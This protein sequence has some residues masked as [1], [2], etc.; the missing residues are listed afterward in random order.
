MPRS[1][2]S[3]GKYKADQAKISRE[4][5]AEGRDIGDVPK[6][7]NVRRK[8]KCSLSFR[9]FCDTYLPER[10]PLSWSGDHLKAIAKL[11]TAVLE[12]G[13]FAFA[14]PRG[15]GKTT[16][17]ESAALWA[18]LY[19]HRSFVVLIGSTEAAAEEMLESIKIELETNDEL[20]A[21]FPEVCFPIRAL[22]GISNRCKGQTI[23]GERT[24]IEWTQKDIV[25]PTVQKSKASGAVL[26]VAGITGRI[27]GMK[28]S[29]SDGRIIRPDFVIPDDPQTDDSAVSVTQNDYREK[30][31]AGAVL[32]L[33][34]PK[35][36]ISAVMPCTVI[37]P[38]DMADR[39]LNR[40]IHPE[41]NG[42]R[43]KMVYAFPTDTEKWERYAE[44]RKDGMRAGDAGK[45]ATEFYAENREAMDAGS[46]VAWPD[47]FNA[48][49]LSAIQNAMNMQ[50][51]NPR[52]F[53]AEAQNEPL[54]I[55]SGPSTE[56]TS[57]QIL[58]KLN[59]MPRG[60]IPRECTRLT[61]FIDVGQQVLI[62][63][64][65]A[66]DERFGGAAVDYGCF[67]VQNRDY[68]DTSDPRPSLSDTFPGCSS[69]AL[70]YQGLAHLVPWLLSR[71]W[72]QDQTGQP[73][74]IN[75]L[76]VD[77]GWQAETVFKYVRES[78]LQ[79]LVNGSKGHAIKAR[80]KP[81]HEWPV[82]E[83]TRPIFH[84]R[85]YPPERGK[86]R[87]VLFDANGWKSFF[88]DRLRVPKGT[89]GGFNLF[90]SEAETK[91]GLHRALIE[92]LTSERE[93]TVKDET[94]GR[95]KTEWQQIPHRPNHLWDCFVGCCVAAAVD[96]LQWSPDATPT[97]KRV[98]PK[99]DFEAA[100]KRAA[101]QPIL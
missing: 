44:L 82:K 87:W 18:I 52:A 67:P 70:V 4:R 66:F 80:H 85:V 77:T 35:K 28:A 42:E 41:W 2:K 46:E 26:R 13:R 51:D 72:K 63:G 23:H 78:G 33:A 17:S 1:E 60:T 95:T 55:D 97:V 47:R 22:D 20:F 8:K 62:Y 89:H 37:A 27:R 45:A 36:K 53:A 10:F 9:H 71:E 29:K 79:T 99:I 90:G 81:M 39:I 74:K 92:H 14:M 34:G 58:A 59:N 96:G 57:I 32:G 6:V 7:A 93:H 75:R 48:D 49:E 43:F 65:A 98:R 69:T 11:Q 19:G 61:A 31:L 15:S 38:N 84:G 21:D 73:L 40:D 86:G 16:L 91:S 25:L 88:A 100:A 76:L 83:G 94:T 54:P 56:L 12:G 68:F 24:R 3:Y 5:S 30:V 64:V 50:I 101:E